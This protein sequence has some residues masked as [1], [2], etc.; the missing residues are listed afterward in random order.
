[1]ELDDILWGLP[2]TLS[3][4]LMIKTENVRLY[5]SKTQ[6]LKE[7]SDVGIIFSWTLLPDK[8][9][10]EAG[11][12]QQGFTTIALPRDESFNLIYRWQIESQNYSATI[13]NVTCAPENLPEK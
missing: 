13:D 2:Y 11:D 12:W 5:P 8:G 9:E 3:H 6:W 4:R 1:M 10:F 7:W